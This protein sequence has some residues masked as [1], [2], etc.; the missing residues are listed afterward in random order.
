MT[1]SLAGTQVQT[2]HSM[3]T[4]STL[5]ARYLIKA[6]KRLITRL[7]VACYNQNIA[8]HLGLKPIVFE[9]DRIQDDDLGSVTTMRSACATGR[10]SLGT[11]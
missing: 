5:Y 4:S 3:L 8:F 7:V 6:I 10:D 1:C 11:T 2:E 9:I